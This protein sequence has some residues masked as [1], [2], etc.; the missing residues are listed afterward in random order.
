MSLAQLWRN[1]YLWH[2]K[3]WLKCK[4][5]STTL[6]D[7]GWSQRKTAARSRP[8]WSMGPGRMRKLSTLTSTMRRIG[9]RVPLDF[10]NTGEVGINAADD[11]SY[12]SEHLPQVVHADRGDDLPIPPFVPLGIKNKAGHFYSVDFIYYRPVSK[13]QVSGQSHGQHEVAQCSW[14][15]RRESSSRQH[16]LQTSHHCKF[17]WSIH[18]EVHRL[19]ENVLVVIGAFGPSS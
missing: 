14:F 5:M 16:S 6:S 12:V 17:A 2:V 10:W 9:K 15:D 19:Q 11:T 18:R 3:I 8:G 13:R 7:R 4:R 1:T